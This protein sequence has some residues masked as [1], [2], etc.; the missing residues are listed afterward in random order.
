[1]AEQLDA[2]SECQWKKGFIILVERHEQLLNQKNEF[3]SLKFV[4][5]KK[6]LSKINENITKS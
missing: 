3:G 4:N 1:M 2:R 6:V 5:N